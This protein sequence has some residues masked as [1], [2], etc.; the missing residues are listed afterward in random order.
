[1]IKS[2]SELIKLKTFEER[3][4]Y[5]KLKG[6]VGAST[7]GYD[8][9]LNQILYTSNRWQER[10]RNK[11]IIRDLGCDLGIEG[12]EIFGKIIIHH[13]NP[14][15]INDLR[16]QNEDIFNPEFLITTSFRTHQALHYGSITSLDFKPI[17]RAKNDTSPWL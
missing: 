4:E 8:R 10:V 9:Y 1:M 17:L 6:N 14:L 3:F 2:F 13:I 5:L 15:S 12:Y 16:T 7:F 11:I